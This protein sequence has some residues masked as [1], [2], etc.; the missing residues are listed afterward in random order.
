MSRTH[1]SFARTGP[2]TA[3]VAA[4][5][6]VPL[7]ARQAESEKAVLQAIA[8]VN[9]AFQRADVKAYDALTTSDFLRVGSNGRVI[10]KATWLKTV[11]ANSGPARKPGT[12]DETSVR[13]YGD[14]AVVTYRNKPVTSDG[15]PGP[16]GYLTR[17]FEKQG[18][19]WK[20]AFTQSTDLQAPA[21]PTTPAPPPLPAWS[22]STPLEKEALAAFQAI[23]KAN[24]DRDVAAWERL[25]APDHLIITAEGRKTTRA[26]RVAALKAPPAANA[27]APTA[28]SDLRLMV[29]GGGLAVVSWRSGPASNPT[30]SLKVLAKRG[31][32]WQQVLQQG[33]PIVA[34]KS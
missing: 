7:V 16:V 28:M 33:S 9:E 3:L 30:R 25:S 10:G 15:T 32:A 34:P 24:A 4:L 31:T 1:W 2:A 21:A 13:V 11:V 8:A 6:I 17:V 12:F 26:E 29:K 22:A 19:Q 18:G 27:A 23:Q 14:A 20:L 5:V